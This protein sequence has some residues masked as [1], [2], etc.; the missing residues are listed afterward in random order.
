[1]YRAGGHKVLLAPATEGHAKK[2]SGPGG[3]LRF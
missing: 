1:M 3:R 2:R